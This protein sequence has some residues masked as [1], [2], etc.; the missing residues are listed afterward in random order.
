MQVGKTI[1]DGFQL[2]LTGRLRFLAKTW[3]S[4]S[5]I[6]S[7]EVGHCLCT[8][9]LSICMNPLRK[10]PVRKRELR[11]PPDPPHSPPPSEVAL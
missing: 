4:W 3:S 8:R 1:W 7:T 6:C 10:A 5:F 11:C 2:F 9:L